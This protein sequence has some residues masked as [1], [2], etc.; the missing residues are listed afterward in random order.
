MRLNGNHCSGNGNQLSNNN[1]CEIFI[2]IVESIKVGRFIAKSIA[3]KINQ[4]IKGDINGIIKT[5]Y[6]PVIHIHAGIL[7]RYF[8]ICRAELYR[9][10]LIARVFIDIITKRILDLVVA[11][12]ILAL[13]FPFIIPAVLLMIARKIKLVRTIGYG[14][15]GRE[16]SLFHFSS[17]KRDSSAGLLLRYGIGGLPKLL[18]IYR[19]DLSLVGPRSLPLEQSSMQTRHVRR[20]LA[21]RPGLIGPWWLKVR[22]NI[23]YSNEWDNDIE[24]INKH[25][26]LNDIGICIRS[27][28]AII[29]GNRSQ[30]QEPSVN[31]F[32]IEID[33]LTIH[34]AV[35][36]II[37]LLNA[38]RPVR[39][40]FVNTDCMNL[41]V[42]DHEYRQ[43]LNSSE[44]VMAD[45]IGV[46]IACKMLGQEICQNVNGTD[47]FPLL[48]EKLAISGKR[49]FLLGCKAGTTKLVADRLLKEYPGINI[50]GYYHGY[51]SQDEIPDVIAR[52]KNSRTDILFTAMGAPYQEKWLA[53][54]LNETGATVGI[55][56]GGLF[57]FYSSSL[58]RG[59]LWMREMGLEWVFRLYQ[60]PVRL[61]KR[62]LVGNVVFLFRVIS[63]KIARCLKQYD[64]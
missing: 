33:N 60:E 13:I 58:K 57:D 59:P 21:V 2:I 37:D 62:Y 26:I 63:I 40:S 46:R 22:G 39:A 34:E 50:A 55:A 7:R 64:K 9:L 36:R 23:D 25:R 32:G 3:M 56:V 24:Y 61:W 30:K 15:N 17:D 19:G 27:I 48:C 5:Y 45:G 47:L 29:H 8:T 18:S 53:D 14:L 16:I 31:L 6:F 1:L 54:N 35:D 44:L 41:S 12:V 51:F 10:D 4:Q 49:I 20:R 43:V 42:H 52:I 28:P 38:S 11:T